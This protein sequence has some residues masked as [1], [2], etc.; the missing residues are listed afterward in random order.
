MFSLLGL[1]A[2]A[3]KYVPNNGYQGP[4]YSPN[5]PGIQRVTITF[6]AHPADGSTIIVPDATALGIPVTRTFH[7]QYGGS[8]GAFIIVLPS[9]GGT[10]AQVAAATAAA[11]SDDLTSWDTSSPSATSVRIQSA[12]PGRNVTLTGTQLTGVE[13]YANATLGRALPAAAGPVMA[14][15][16]SFGLVQQEI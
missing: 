1:L 13:V 2:G 7:F 3:S 4:P 14:T 10:T 11:F 9:G 5:A 16:P 15:M 12:L 6:N 8:P